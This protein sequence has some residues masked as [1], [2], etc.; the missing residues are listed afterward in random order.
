M[1][2]ILRSQSNG[3]DSVINGHVT[4]IVTGQHIA[5]ATVNYAPQ[6]RAAD[7]ARWLRGELSIKPTVALAAR[8]FGVSAPL[9]A[10]ARERLE[11]RERAKRHVL[12]DLRQRAAGLE[13]RIDHDDDD[14]DPKTDLGPYWLCNAVTGK[15]IWPTGLP[16][17]G[18]AE[19]LDC[20]ERERALPPGADIAEAWVGFGK[21]F[22]K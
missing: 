7:A 18:I 2:D 22:G 12:V 4:P 3:N 6:Q 11:Q 16:F 1:L 8:T 14:L 15:V 9:I 19:A 20:L 21:F 5:K 17:A 13:A 10:E